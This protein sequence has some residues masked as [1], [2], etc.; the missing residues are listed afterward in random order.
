M[1]VKRLAIVLMIAVLCTLPLSAF[2]AAHSA[3]KTDAETAAELGLL[4]GDGNGVDAAYL[5]KKSTRIQAAIISLRL[6]GLVDEAMSHSGKSNFSDAGK[7]GK[8]N[9]AIL[10]YLK[11]HPELG[12]SGI[13]NGRFN[14]QEEISSQQLYKVLLEI[15]GYRSG[16][17]FAYAETEKFA[18]MKGLRE[19]SGTSSL[20]N[21]HIATALV[22]ALNVETKS[23]GMLF[24]VLKSNGIIP[25]SA[26]LPDGKII[27]WSDD[28]VGT[29]FTD[30]EGRTLYIFTKDADDLN[31][32]QGNCLVNWPI[33]YAEHLQVP[34]KLNKDDF[35]A[36]TREDGSMQTTYK[37][38][39]LY[40]FIQDKAPGDVNGQGVGGVWFA[41]NAEIDPITAGVPAEP[42]EPEVK[43][44]NVDIKDFSFGTE[45]LTIEAGSKVVF[46]NH[47]DMAHNAV[48]VDGS[49]ETPLLA[50]GESFTVT[51]DKEGTYD[52]FCEPHKRF[53][54][55]QIIVK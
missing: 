45:P 34:G 38:W 15:A 44:Y 48:A 37:G 11:E 27:L 21:A 20:T 51:F 10:A 2:A 43:T 41:A 17:D 49:F 53:M 46:T 26:S 23:G 50:K 12:W 47:D 40:Y 42:T 31:S 55:G 52:Y 6:Q 5:A 39:P 22:E 25:E 3:V 18:E 13:G 36:I 1:S 4:L 9:Q 32:C 29:F 24:T 7:V 14:P 16:E 35:S 28:K 30:S 54:T 8:S 33:F 19:I